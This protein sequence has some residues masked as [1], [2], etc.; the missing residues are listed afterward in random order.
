MGQGGDLSPYCKLD[1]LYFDNS[2]YE[3][4][5]HYRL[6]KYL[7]KHPIVHIN[8]NVDFYITYMNASV[9]GDNYRFDDVSG[10]LLYK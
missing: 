5:M 8:D 7:E 3:N 9:E 4:E 10:Y 2:L 6:A 1:S